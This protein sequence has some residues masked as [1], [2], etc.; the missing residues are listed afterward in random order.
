MNEDVIY[1]LAN[2]QDI[3]VDRF[4]T[5]IFPMKEL[6]IQAENGAI[7]KKYQNEGIYILDGK[8]KQNQLNLTRAEGTREETIAEDGESVIYGGLKLSPITDDQITSNVEEAAGSNKIVSAV[9]DLYETIQQIE[10]KKEIEVKR[11]KFLTPKEVM[12]EGGRKITLENEN[13]ENRYLV[14]SKGGLTNIYSDEGE[15][16]LYAYDNVGT[17]LDSYGNEI[18]RRGELVTRNQIMAIKE[19]QVTDTKDS[20]AVCLDTI[21]QYEGI[22]RNTESM[23]EQGQTAKEILE[24]NLKDYEILNL[25][26]CTLDAMLYYVNQDIPVLALQDSGE[27]D[28][29]IGFNQQNVVLMDPKTGKIY[30]KGMNDSRE[31]YD[32]NGNCFITYIRQ[33]ENGD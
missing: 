12:Y 13:G 17:V 33:K 9:T 32:K 21:L 1:G 10:L 28:L 4:G 2:E 27:A 23:L 16:V 15:A 8:I 19:A 20:L 14:Y 29:I 5:S 26:G 25:K 30:K 11:L 22:S 3:A 24:S 6:I 7:L 18:Y 31:M